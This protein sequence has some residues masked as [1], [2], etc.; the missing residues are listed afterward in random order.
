MAIT[1]F[2][3]LQTGNVGVAGSTG[4]VVYRNLIAIRAALISRLPAEAAPRVALEEP[5]IRR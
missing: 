4:A 3:V 2:E 5:A 1:A